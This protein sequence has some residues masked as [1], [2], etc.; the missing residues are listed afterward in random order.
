MLIILLQ[1]ANL[2]RKSQTSQITTWLYPTCQ[3][4]WVYFLPEVWRNV[5]NIV[6]VTP[7][8]AQHRLASDWIL[9][10]SYWTRYGNIR[11]QGW[12]N[13]PS[14]ARNK[15]AIFPYCL[16]KDDIY[17]NVWFVH[18]PTSGRIKWYTAGSSGRIIVIRPELWTDSFVHQKGKHYLY[19]LDPRRG[20][21]QLLRP[22]VLLWINIYII[23]INMSPEGG[24]DVCSLAYFHGPLPPRSVPF[25]WAAPR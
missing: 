17:G 16:I 1:I 8:P 19:S 13:I 10:N 9:S 21:G 15:L 22:L 18:C 2:D 3:G 12:P 5:I 6:Y 25:P 24:L 20:E 23:C 11:L 14:L 4:K 7:S